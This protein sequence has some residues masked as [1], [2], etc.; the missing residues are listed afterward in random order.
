MAVLPDKHHRGS[1]SLSETLEHLARCEPER[2]YALI[3]RGREISHGFRDVTVRELI[4]AIDACAWWI[5]DS[6]GRSDD[7]ETLAYVGVADLRYVLFF[8]AAIKCGYK[9]RICCR[10]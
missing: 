1:R 3:P 9:V 5:S 8:Y 7:F 10:V 4:H 6:F 2:V